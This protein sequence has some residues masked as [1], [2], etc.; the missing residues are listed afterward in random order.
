MCKDWFGEVFITRRQR[1]ENV[2][3][4]KKGPAYYLMLEINRFVVR[5]KKLF[6]TWWTI[7]LQNMFPFHFAANILHKNNIF[8]LVIRD[9]YYLSLYPVVNY[10]FMTSFQIILRTEKKGNGFMSNNSEIRYLFTYR[11]LQDLVSGQHYHHNILIFLPQQTR[12]GSYY[13]WY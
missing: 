4:L 8:S 6:M 7:C 2:W 9:V 11:G 13:Q 3:E 12:T 10:Y 1:S 5:Q